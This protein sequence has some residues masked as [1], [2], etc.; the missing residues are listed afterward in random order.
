MILKNGPFRRVHVVTM[1]RQTPACLQ[2]NQVLRSAVQSGVIRI[3]HHD[4]FMPAR[5]LPTFNSHAIESCLH[6]IPGLCDQFMYFNDDF[7]MTQRVSAPQ[8]FSGTKIVVRG[9]WSSLR[10]EWTTP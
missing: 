1:R 3:V 6:Y 7:Y 8:L 10:E 2:G 5:V 4:E 9:V